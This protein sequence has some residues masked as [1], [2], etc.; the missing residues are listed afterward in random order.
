M[1]PFYEMKKLLHLS[2]NSDDGGKSILDGSMGHHA[3]NITASVDA[4]AAAAAA[5]ADANDS[6]RRFIVL[7]RRS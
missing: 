4:A 7:N 5:E 2:V 6:C 1:K 3:R